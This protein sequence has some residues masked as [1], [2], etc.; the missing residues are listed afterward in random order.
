MPPAIQIVQQQLVLPRNLVDRLIALQF[1]SRRI[2][3]RLSCEQHCIH[4]V[5]L[6]HDH[7]LE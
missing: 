7:D 2:I 3:L 1:Q 6:D 4:S 5:V